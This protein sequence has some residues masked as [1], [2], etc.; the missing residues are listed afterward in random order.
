[1]LRGQQNLAA[2]RYKEALAD[3][4]TALAVPDNL[5]TRGPGAAGPRNAEAAYL[6]GLAYEGLG[7]QAKA[8][9][10]WNKAIAPAPSGGRRG[11]GGSDGPA[12]PVPG[13]SYYQALCLQKLGQT[14]K[15]KAIF[16]GLVDSGQGALTQAAAAGGGRG[17]QSPR[18]RAANAH[19]SIGLGY[20]GLGDMAKAK[21]ELAQAVDTSPDLLGAR[22]ALAGMK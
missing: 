14:D 1:M 8:I 10:S 13:Q 17:S 7:D 4:A 11:S 12:A 22:T 15:A 3:F 18:L 9:E 6:T 19:Y 2:K 20:M 5:P 16:Q 21:A